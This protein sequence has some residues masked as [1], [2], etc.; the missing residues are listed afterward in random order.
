MLPSFR[1]ESI[2]SLRHTCATLLM[3]A[4]ENPKV[5]AERLGNSI[6]VTLK[7]YSHVSPNMQ[8]SASD[9][10]EAMLK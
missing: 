2:H 7:T 1:R 4:G 6:E 3:L 5:V 10:L 9:K 8:K